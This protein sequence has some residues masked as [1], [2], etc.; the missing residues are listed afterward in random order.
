MALV[1]RFTYIPIKNVDFLELDPNSFD[2]NILRRFHYTIFH[3]ILE[4]R[5]DQF[6]LVF[7]LSKFD[8]LYPI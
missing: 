1:D 4:N 6:T 7:L 8:N 5:V 3:E 2:L